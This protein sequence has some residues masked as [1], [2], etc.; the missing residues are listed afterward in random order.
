MV[1]LDT[2]NAAYVESRG[3]ASSIQYGQV[4]VP[5]CGPTDVLV[6]VEAVA[7]NAVDTFV[8][9]G[10]YQTAMP[11]PFVVGRDLV[12]TV[13]ACGSGI[14]GFRPGDL[15]WTNSLGHGGRQGAAAQ[16]AVV[17]AD[18]LYHAPPGADPVDLV[19]VVH[20]A[21]TAYL[22]IVVHGRARAGETVLVAGAAGHVGRAATVFATRV[23]ASVVATASAADLDACRRL[24]AREAFDYRDPRLGYLLRDAAPD[25]VDV[26]LDTSGHHD[27]ELA[28]ELLAP[29]G[30]IVLMA[31]LSARPGL[32]VGPL[33]T[34]D[35][36]IV[37]YAISNASTTELAAAAEQ[38]SRLV[39]EGTLEPGPIE[40]LPLDRAGEAHA[41]IETGNAAGARLV[42][43]PAAHG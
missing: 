21:A 18:R 35:G 27:L 36:R 11:F 40:E 43:R 34:R 32:P 16:F 31:G 33:Y 19:A 38:I 30:R 28:V 6:Q 3:P 1:G 25:G 29:R 17:A 12:G 15:V 22:G 20:P 42:L 9:S 14:T 26:H 8:R 10:A 5:R 4:P 13:V 39:G 7:V 24:G 2:M 23:G 37:G 41:R